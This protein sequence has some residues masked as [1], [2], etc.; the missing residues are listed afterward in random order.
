MFVA[1]MA[2][3]NEMVACFVAVGA[4]AGLSL[5]LWIVYVSLSSHEYIVKNFRDI[6]RFSV[7]G[8]RSRKSRRGSH[9]NRRV[10]A[11]GGVVLQR[12]YYESYTETIA[13]DNRDSRPT[14]S[15]HGERKP[16]I[17]VHPILDMNRSNLSLK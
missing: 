11:G 8:R 5:V 6:L 2:D 7:G 9:G 12:G 1:G 13:G 10:A 17:K 16:Q 14:S 15:D 4:L 3:N